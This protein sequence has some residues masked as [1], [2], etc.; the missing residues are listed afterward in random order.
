MRGLGTEV[1]GIWD[2]GRS[3]LCIRGVLFFSPFSGRFLKKKGTKLQEFGAFFW[4]IAHWAYVPSLLLFGLVAFSRRGTKS[5]QA[6]QIL[7]NHVIRLI[8]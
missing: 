8:V 1:G 4:A 7:C 2:E 3:R 6:L 5:T